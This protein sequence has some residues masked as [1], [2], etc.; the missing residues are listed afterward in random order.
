[1]PAI[2]FF[3]GSFHLNRHNGLSKHTSIRYIQMPFSGSD[4]QMM[5]SEARFQL[6]ASSSLIAQAPAAAAEMAPN[7]NAD[8][9]IWRS[10]FVSSILHVLLHSNHTESSS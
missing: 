3:A 7:Y 4:T 6:N 9:G 5:H 2:L 8:A 10:P 1:M